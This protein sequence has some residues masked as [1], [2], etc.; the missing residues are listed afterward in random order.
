MS[1]VR[2]PTNIFLLCKDCEVDLEDLRL[3]CIYCTNELTTAEVLSF[4]WKELC[5][6]WDHELP[7]GACAQCL[8]KA[9]KVRELRHWSHSSY[10]ATVEE[11]TKTPLAQL[12]IRCHMCLKPLSSQEKEYLV[13]TGDRFH[14]IAGQWTGRC[15]HCR[16][17][18][19]AIQQQ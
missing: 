13:Q 17:P 19:T 4:A 9:A 7:Y 2:Y 14:N 18:C 8:R 3:I 16:A 10:G 6:K 12:Y 15:C 5:I 11:E 1:G